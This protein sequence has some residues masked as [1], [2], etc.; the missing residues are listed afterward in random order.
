MICGNEQD[1]FPIDIAEAVVEESADYIAN[2]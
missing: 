2:C 1:Q